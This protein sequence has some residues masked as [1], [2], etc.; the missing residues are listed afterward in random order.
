MKKQRILLSL[1]FLCLL[2]VAGTTQAATPSV[3]FQATDNPG[4]WFECANTGSTLSIGCVPASIIA[5]NSEQKSLAVVRPGDTIAFASTGQANTLHTAVSLIY[6]TGASFTPP[7][8][9][10]ESS[11]DVDLDPP[12]LNHG[13]GS[14][15]SVTLDTPGLHVFFCDIHP[16]MFAAVIVDDSKTEGL[17]LGATVD[18]PKVLGITKLPTT[19]DLALRLVRAFFVITDPNNWQVFPASGAASYNTSYPPVSVNAGGAV[20]PNLDVFLRDYF[21]EG[22]LGTTNCVSPSVTGCPRKQLAA[23]IPPTHPG[24]GQVWVDTQLEKMSEKSK[25]GTATAV[26][27]TS[28]HVERK[29]GLPHIGHR[30]DGM[31]NPHNMWTDRD[32]K[33]IY[34]T[35]WFDNT[36]AVFNRTTGHF[37]RNTTAG[38]AT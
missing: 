5:Q 37:V 36:L 7:G 33:L 3:T 25:P 6:P 34:Q 29:V 32:Q 26:N 14:S 2:G 21:K 24:V 22:G 35:Q 20:V 17:D 16:Y 11:F 30:N 27:A 8:G 1:A 31:N 4:G 15:F 13:A 28:W 12:L 19:S 10:P 9:L 38:P 18:L 23:P